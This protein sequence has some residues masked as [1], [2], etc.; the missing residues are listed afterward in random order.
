MDFILDDVK[1]DITDAK[2]FLSHLG[3]KGDLQLLGQGVE[4]NVYGMKSVAIKLFRNRKSFE[5]LEYLRPRY[6]TLKTIQKRCQEGIRRDINFAPILDVECVKVAGEERLVAYM[7]KLDGKSMYDLGVPEIELGSAGWGIAAFRLAE[8]LYEVG[9]DGFAKYLEDAIKLAEIGISYEDATLSNHVISKNP[10][11]GKKHISRIDLWKGSRPW[12][13]K[14][15]GCLPEVLTRDAYGLV[16]E[17]AL[18]CKQLREPIF[19]FLEQAI[20][21]AP[22]NRMALK[23]HESYKEAFEI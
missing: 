17:S 10:L 1:K 18:A 16:A 19:D 12:G 20:K 13:G 23:R 11:D 22:H 14:L 8:E 3:A 7:P 4:A 2:G 6:G 9:E 21:R 5:G 15:G